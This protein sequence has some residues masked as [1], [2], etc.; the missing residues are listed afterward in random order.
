LTLATFPSLL[1]EDRLRPITD[2]IAFLELPHAETVRAYVDWWREIRADKTAQGELAIVPHVVS[3]DLD[4]ILRELAPLRFVEAN[5]IA[6][7][8]TTGDWTAIFGNGLPL[9]YLNSIART[10]TRRIGRTSLRLTVHVDRLDGRSRQ[11]VYLPHAEFDLRGPS[12][13]Q[14]VAW[15]NDDFEW[16]WD[17]FGDPQDFERGDR[18]SA[19]EVRDRLTVGMIAD[20]AAAL[21]IRPFD[22][23][24]YA[25][26]GT[27]TI[28]ERAAAPQPHIA[29]QSLA[30]VQERIANGWYADP[31]RDAPPRPNG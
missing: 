13:R 1:L 16:Q 25:P 26:D 5:R 31:R 9:P 10:L 21:G 19:P 14:L 6:F 20:Y 29:T 24:F 11:T 17:E 30:E 23:S 4:A 18:Y 28:V 22:A 12:Q 15:I 7:I 27:A 3:G 8:P 2:Q